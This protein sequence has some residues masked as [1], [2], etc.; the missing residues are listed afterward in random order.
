LWEVATAKPRAPVRRGRCDL[1]AAAAF[2]PDGR[3]LLTSG[4]ILA[5]APGGQPADAAPPKEVQALLLRLLPTHEEV[6][7]LAVP[8][9]Y[10]AS[11]ACSP[12]GKLVA[13][14]AGRDIHLWRV[15]EAARA[16]RPAP[17]M[18]SAAQLEALWKELEGDDA[19]RAYAA[20]QALVAAPGSAVPFLRARLP[21]VV[22]VDGKRIEQLIADLEEPK[23]VTREKAMTDLRNMKELPE[24][25]L[26]RTLERPNLML[27]A[28]RRIEQLLEGI[29]QPTPERLR[30]LRAVEALEHMR[31]AESRRLLEALSQ[32]APEGLL[33]REARAALARLK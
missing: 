26:R 11:V 25:A 30:V 16:A 5:P 22:P 6:A 19:A 12:D 10:L 31:E 23:F 2:S 29:A 8:H 15:P 3:L 28:R 1:A 33:T 20:V 21:N 24:P 14:A 17:R 7:R 18:L 32:G 9:P 4:T 13:G 27:E